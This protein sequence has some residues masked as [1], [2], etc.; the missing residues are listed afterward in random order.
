MGFSPISANPCVG[1]AVTGVFSIVLTINDLPPE[2][3]FDIFSRLDLSS[4]AALKCTNKRH[5]N[6]GR[7]VL[8]DNLKHAMSV[9]DKL[10]P[11]ARKMLSGN[12]ILLFL[13]VYKMDI[14]RFLRDDRASKLGIQIR[15]LDDLSALNLACL[16]IIYQLKTPDIPFPKMP[17]LK[18]QDILREGG[19]G[20]NSSHFF[21]LFML[22]ITCLA[23]QIEFLNAFHGEIR[24]L[25]LRNIDQKERSMLSYYSDEYMFFSIVMLP[26]LSLPLAWLLQCREVIQFPEIKAE[27]PDHF[28]KKQ[29]IA[30]LELINRELDRAVTRLIELPNQLK[31][32]NQCMVAASVLLFVNAFLWTVAV[33]SI[34][35]QLSIV[36]C[37]CLPI[38]IGIFRADVPPGVSQTTA[39]LYGVKNFTNLF[40]LFGSYVGTYWMLIDNQTV[41]DFVDEHVFFEARNIKHMVAACGGGVASGVTNGLISGAEYLAPIVLRGATECLS[42]TASTAWTYLNTWRR[43][44]RQ[45][46]NVEVDLEREG[47]LVEKGMKFE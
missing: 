6:I 8:T 13:K 24:A 36:L 21:A 43:S 38:T 10:T 17:K 37:P 22:G 30:A 28:A 23:W 34:L 12:L 40:L 35:I 45:N 14:A 42:N 41:N 47:L 44:Q 7:K 19:A 2:L 5:A 46:P 3:L 11:D 27:D 15:T 1:F 32:Y 26:L 25:F 33:A 31:L 29:Y 9:Y 18:M 16:E 4:L 20:F 39:N